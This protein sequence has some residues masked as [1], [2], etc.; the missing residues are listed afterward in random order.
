MSTVAPQERS[1]RTSRS[2]NVVVN[3]GYVP[4]TLPRPQG[5]AQ[6]SLRVDEAGGGWALLCLVASLVQR[7]VG[8]PAAVGRGR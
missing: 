5:W 6:R 7:P 1:R 3:D 8:E 4:I 2:M